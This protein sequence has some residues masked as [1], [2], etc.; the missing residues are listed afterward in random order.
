MIAT[1]VLRPNDGLLAEVVIGGA[2]V[3]ELLGR[4]DRGG[5]TPRSHQS[6]AARVLLTEVLR[7]LGHTGPPEVQPTLGGAPVLTAAPEIAVSLSHDGNQCAAAAL[8]PTS[9][10][11]AAVGVDVQGPHWPGPGLLRRTCPPTT[12][13]ALA[14]LPAPERARRFARIWAAQE[15]CVKATGEGLGGAPWRISI[16]PDHDTGRWLGL[17]W[18]Q[19]HART[20]QTALCVAHRTTPR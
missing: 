2:A 6:R 16:D 9:G 12:A 14:A 18:I 3:N 7:A 19:L 1:H 13:T 5:A 20:A 10:G 17:R 11:M 15:A 8:A 4:T